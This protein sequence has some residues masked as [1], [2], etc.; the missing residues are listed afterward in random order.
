MTALGKAALTP[1][2]FPVYT[3]GGVRGV[4]GVPGQDAPR[5]QNLVLIVTGRPS[6]A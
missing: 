5:V 1:V 6:L 2:R 3:T 4:S